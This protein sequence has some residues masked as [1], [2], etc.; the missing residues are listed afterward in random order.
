MSCTSFTV[1]RPATPL[2][3]RNASIKRASSA[4]SK[5]GLMKMSAMVG[6]RSS[7]S[8]ALTSSVST[9]RARSR[10]TSSM[11]RPCRYWYT[12]R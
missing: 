5:W 10:E 8:V 2:R 9:S 4:E 1:G 7:W 6:T 3:C 12:Q 11:T